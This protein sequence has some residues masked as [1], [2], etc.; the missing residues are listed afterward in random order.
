MYRIVRHSTGL[1]MIWIALGSVPWPKDRGSYVLCSMFYWLLYPTGFCGAWR[2]SSSLNSREKPFSQHIQH[3]PSLKLVALSALW[4]FPLAVMFLFL[5]I[6]MLLYL[7]PDG[8]FPVLVPKGEMLLPPVSSYSFALLR[9][10]HPG[11]VNGSLPTWDRC[12]CTLNTPFWCLSIFLSL[13]ADHKW[14]DRDLDQM[15]KAALR[16]FIVRLVYLALLIFG[17]DRCSGAP[18]TDLALWRRI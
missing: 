17:L 16:E 7:L 18:L 15:S 13:R 6:L 2:M 12:L 8:R 3:L 1:P 5:N 14:E 11:L 9:L 10:H 4:S